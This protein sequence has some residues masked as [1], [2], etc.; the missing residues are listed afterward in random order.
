MINLKINLF[1]NI[2]NRL[3]MWK[4]IFIIIDL[5]YIFLLLVFVYS[6]ITSELLNPNL[7][8]LISSLKIFLL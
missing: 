4:R 5:F 1:K 8:I 3:L 2:Q 6:F 7:E